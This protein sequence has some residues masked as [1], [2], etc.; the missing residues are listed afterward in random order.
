MRKQDL[1]DLGTLVAVAIL[2]VLELFM[3]LAIGFE[4]AHWFGISQEA[5]N[6]M[7]LFI[8]QP[9][10]FVFVYALFESMLARH[11]GERIA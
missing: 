5:F 3:W 2:C 11:D 10:F 4:W 1:T 6:A 7:A 9:V 8:G